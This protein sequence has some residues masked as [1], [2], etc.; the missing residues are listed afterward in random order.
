MES[1]YD[2]IKTAADLVR[3]VALHGLSTKQE[4]ICRAQDIFG[5]SAVEELVRLA[6][7]NGRNDEHGNP[8][9]KGS[10]SSGRRA[11]QS[12]FYSIAFAIWN[13]EDATRFWNQYTNPDKEM[14]VKTYE[15]NANLKKQNE[16]LTER[17]N[18]LSQEVEEAAN[19]WQSTYEQ[20]REQEERALKAEAEIV[21]LKAKLY[22][23]MTK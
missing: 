5:N 16:T 21:Q 13:W 2:E 1:I 8:D 22:D 23:L 7:D 17:R 10:W 9:P 11:T 19:K 18:Q 4:D 15:E 3:E 12:I 6:N 14:L 20:F